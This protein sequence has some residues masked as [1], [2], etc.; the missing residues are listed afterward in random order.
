MGRGGILAG[1]TGSQS[2][3]PGFESSCCRFEALTISF[4]PHC[5]SSLSCIN[6]HLVTDRRGYVNEQSSRSNC[7][8][9][10]CFP[11]E[12]DVAL[13]LTGQPGGEV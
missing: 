1:T 13:E 2:R 10:G 8:V 5:H 4:T 9:A 7:S 6:E 3:E 12:A 11:R